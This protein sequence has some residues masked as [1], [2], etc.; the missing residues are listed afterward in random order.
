MKISRPFCLSPTDA[1]QG[2]AK[3][4][5]HLT[6]QVIRE[7]NRHQNKHNHRQNPP[8]KWADAEKRT[9]AASPPATNHKGQAGLVVR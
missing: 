3:P 5:L 2:S 6:Q 4:G 8:W 9:V 1:L 7:A